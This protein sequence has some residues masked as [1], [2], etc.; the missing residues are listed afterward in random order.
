[1]KPLLADKNHFIRSFS[2]PSLAFLLR[3]MPID[4]VPQALTTVFDSLKVEANQAVHFIEALAIVI[5]EAV[6]GPQHGFHSHVSDFL[7]ILLDLSTSADSLD[8]KCFIEDHS[9]LRTRRYGDAEIHDIGRHTRKQGIYGRHYSSTCHVPPKRFELLFHS[10]HSIAQSLRYG[11][12]W[13][14]SL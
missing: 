6:K 12:I 9:N 8:G 10:R 13:K 4:N 5:F 3:K 2:A 11:E 14:Q 1:M 7:C